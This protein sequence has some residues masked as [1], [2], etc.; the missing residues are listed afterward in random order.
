MVKEEQQ[1][2]S[3]LKLTIQTAETQT[4]ENSAKRQHFQ[5]TNMKRQTLQNGFRNKMT[6]ELR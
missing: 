6:D 4:E 3:H 2:K 1:L 5:S